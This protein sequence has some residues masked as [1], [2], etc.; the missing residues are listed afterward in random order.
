M[1]DK[2][3]PPMPSVN[4]VW[5]HYKGGRYA[6]VGKCRLAETGELGVLYRPIGREQV[7]CRPLTEWHEP[8]LM[9]GVRFV[10]EAL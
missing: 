10:K 1:T 7:W 3:S 6:V 9:G 4:T 8:V 5:R 2:T